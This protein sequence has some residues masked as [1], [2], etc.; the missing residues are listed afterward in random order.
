MPW[1]LVTFTLDNIEVKSHSCSTCDKSF[2][3]K[4][5]LSKHI[6]RWHNEKKVWKCSACDKSFTRNKVLTTHMAEVHNIKRDSKW[7]CKKCVATFTTNMKLVNHKK[8][9]HAIISKCPQCSEEFRSEEAVMRHLSENHPDIKKPFACR[10]CDAGFTVKYSLQHHISSV[11]KEKKHLCP[12]CGEGFGM[13][14]LLKKTYR[15]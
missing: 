10:N 6:E 12:T 8:E 1:I 5:S 13:E 7:G 2:R 15:I 11:H 9:A 4:T 14:K 3:K